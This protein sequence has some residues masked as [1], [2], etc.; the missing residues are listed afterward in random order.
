LT[1]VFEVFFE[2]P[3]AAQKTSPLAPKIM[4]SIRGGGTAFQTALFRDITR[5]RSG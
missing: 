3:L 2:D 5:K 4:L 1:L